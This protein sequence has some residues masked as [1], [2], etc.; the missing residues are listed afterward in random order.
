MVAQQVKNPTRICEGAG[1]IP[2]LTLGKIQC[3]CRLWRRLQVQLG[4]GVAGVV[5]WA[6]SCSSDWTTSPRNFHSVQMHQGTLRIM[7]TDEYIIHIFFK[8]K[9]HGRNI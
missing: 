2:G 6:G 9:I 8:Y 7:H 3:C 5:A 4:S 1:V